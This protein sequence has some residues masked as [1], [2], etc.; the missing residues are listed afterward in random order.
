MN[1]SAV[2][3]ALVLAEVINSDVARDGTARREATACI[4]HRGRKSVDARKPYVC[5]R[6]E[7]VPDGAPGLG[8][9]RPGHHGCRKL[10]VSDA[11]TAKRHRTGRRRRLSRSL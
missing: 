5:Y 6:R 1:A 2:T 3:S 9:G 10:A 4:Y 11:E 8:R 7:Q